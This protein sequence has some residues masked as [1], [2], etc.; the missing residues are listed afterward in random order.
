MSRASAEINDHNSRT[1]GVHGAGSGDLVTT[2]G[3]QTLSGKTLT[4]PT[5]NT[6]TIV[7]P[8]GVPISK[9]VTFTEDATSVTHT[10]SVTIPAG[11]TLH[12]ILITSSVLWTDSSA[13]LDVGD[14]DDADGWFAGVNLAATDLLVGEELRMSDATTGWGGK[15]GVYLVAATGR[16]GQATASKAATRYV[17]AGTVVGVVSVTTPSGTAG[18]TFMTV[19]YSV[20]SV[21][22]ATVA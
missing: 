11:A 12:D 19:T 17:T 4:S 16:R 14:A 6:P 7:D 9:T 15:N 21:T 22:A 3:T 13:S 2:T 18:R 20:P 1:S 10:G 5:V 8:V